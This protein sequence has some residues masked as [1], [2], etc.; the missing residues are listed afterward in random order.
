MLFFKCVDA[1][2]NLPNQNSKPFFI[3]GQRMNF[4]LNNHTQS[5]YP[6]SFLDCFDCESKDC[7]LYCFHTVLRLWLECVQKTF[8]HHTGFNHRNN[9]FCQMV[10]SAFDVVFM[11]IDIACHNLCKYKKTNFEKILDISHDFDID[12]EMI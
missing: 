6:C 2:L 3:Y 12:D 8:I 9:A 1:C 11:N 5:L 7:K 4:P 10:V